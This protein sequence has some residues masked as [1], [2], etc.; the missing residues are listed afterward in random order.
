MKKKSI[1]FTQEKSLKLLKTML[2][3]RR[4]E[5]SVNEMF[6][7]GMI[8]GTT[9][10][11]IGQEAL[12]A[13][14]S[15]ALGK[16]DW[17]IPTH[18]GHGHCLAKGSTIEEMMSELFATEQG[19][20]KGLGGS[21]HLMDVKNRNLGNSGVV[22]GAL[23]L[24]V[25]MGLAVK[26]QKRD[27]ALVAFFGDAG[28]NQGM[29]HEAMNLAAIWK[30]PIIFL[31]ENNMYGMS[32][33]A[34]YGVS[35]ENIADRGAGYGIKSLIIDGNNVEEVFHTI[36][37]A[38]QYVKSGKGPML[39]EAKTYRWLGHSKS[40]QRKYRTKEEEV[41]WKLRCPIE[42]FKAKMIEA[43]FITE[44]E[45]E[46]LKQEV[47]KEIGTAITHC[48]NKQPISLEQALDYVLA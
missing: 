47:E 35:I 7:K 18:R 23:P 45:F 21:M 37:E 39:I 43:K 44:S 36:E 46:S 16:K 31:C 19:L 9:H 40:D 5:E 12:H 2:L 13:G 20:C 28:S 32:I 6:M 24:A 22:A 38:T 1:S 27:E 42:N 11:G 26:M 48:E 10:L 17:I 25:G 3:S 30:L 33:P 29:T 4:F 34:K 8:H 14:V 15:S 41:D